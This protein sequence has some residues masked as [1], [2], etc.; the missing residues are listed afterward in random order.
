LKPS[1]LTNRTMYVFFVTECTQNFQNHYGSF[2]HIL[3]LIS[4]QNMCSKCE[5]LAD[6]S[7]DCKQ[8]GK[9]A[10][11]FWAEEL[12]S[13]FIHYL[14]Q[15]RP[16]AD[17]IYDIS[18]N[19]CGYDTQFMLRNFLERRWTPQMVMDGTKILSTIVENLYILDSLNFLPISV[20]TMPKIFDL[21]RKKGYY[22]HIFNTTNNLEYVSPYPEPKYYVAHYM[23]GDDRAQFLEWY[24][25][26][27]VKIVCNKQ[28][29]LAYCMD[30]VN[31]LR[32]A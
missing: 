15:Y 16:F 12:V 8:C 5:A 32:Q 7:V 6:L 25:E 24:E 1:K 31:V 9:L 2:E 3:N 27:K 17:K 22:P 11:V 13:K 18:H 4:A 29:L 14:R 20:K 28:Q 10:H 19:S 26:Q 23:S 21:T 30:D